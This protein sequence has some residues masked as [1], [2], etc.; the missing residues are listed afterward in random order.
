MDAVEDCKNDERREHGRLAPREI[1]YRRKARF[2][3]YAKYDSAIKIERVSARQD[4][5]SCSQKPDPTVDL[6]CP[7]Q[8]QEF[9]NKARGAGQAHIGERKDHEDRR[10]KRHPGDEAT[11]GGDIPRV[12][13]VIDDADA[14]KQGA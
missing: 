5:T 8:R 14:K 12:Y 11:I 2:V 7:D 9:A 4:G 3:E 10:I 1:A 13:P 6:E